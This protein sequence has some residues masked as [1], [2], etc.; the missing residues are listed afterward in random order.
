MPFLTLGLLFIF[1]H[2]SRNFENSQHLSNSTELARSTAYRSN[3]VTSLASIL[4]L[5]APEVM[6]VWSVCLPSAT[7]QSAAV[8]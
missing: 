6:L 5:F 4:F 1:M 7:G 3:E 8:W 2:P